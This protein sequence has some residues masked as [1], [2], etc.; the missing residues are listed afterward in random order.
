MDKTQFETLCRDTCVALGLDNPDALRDDGQIEVDGVDVALFFD[1]EDDADCIFCYVD[2][3]LPAVAHRAQICERLLELNL[4]HGSR[5]AG[6]YAI[7]P[8]S[9]HAVSCLQLH[10]ADVLD[11]EY[12]AEMLQFYARESSDVRDMVANPQRRPFDDAEPAAGQEGG[13]VPHLA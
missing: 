7:D 5:S 6:I 10:D 3:G 1:E 13:L 8:D 11:G 12:V 9:G 2:L 4:H